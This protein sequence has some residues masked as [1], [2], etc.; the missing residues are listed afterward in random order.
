MN[1]KR[2]LTALTAAAAVL[3][4]CATA[5]PPAPS[6]AP[7]AASPEP[8]LKS[9]LDLAGF[10]RSV[11]PQDDL[12]RFVG[13]SWLANTEIPA[14]RSNYGTFQR[15]EDD[16]QAAVRRLVERAA[17]A[18]DAVPGSELQRIGSFYNS[19][20]DTER[21]AS[22]GV[23]PVQGEFAAIAG[24]RTARDIYRWMGRAQRIGLSHPLEFY[25]GQD[26]RNSSAYIAVV[27]QSGLTMPDRDY[28]LKPDATNAEF[29][30]QY[31][32]YVERLLA[33]AGD[34]DAA[35]SAKRIAALETRL[36]NHHWTKVANRDPLKSHNN[37]TLR[38]A[39]QLA[40]G[41]DWASFLDG[42]GAGEVAAIDIRQ[43]TY[44]R[45][46]ARL[47]RMT[48][49]GDWRAY[50]K[51]RVL[52]AY[53]PYLS[54]DFDE[55]QFAFH[56]G[57][58]GGVQ[59]QRP[60]W[61][62]GVQ[63][64]G[65]LMGEA[66]GRLY[67]EE[68]FSADSKARMQALV[69]NLLRAFD[70]SID[71]L[72][73]L[74]PP[75]K[76]EAKRKLAKFTVKIG[77]PDRW[78]DYSKL[79]I[80]ASDLVGNVRRAYEFEFQRTLAKLGQPLDRTEWLMTPQT[81]N[82][83]YYPPMNEIVFPAAILRPP[84][85]DPTADDA[86][87]YG[88]IGAV[89]GHE[90][91]HGFDDQGRQYDGDGNLRDWWTLDDDTRF[92]ARADR[93]VAQFGG[94]DVIDGKRLNGNLTLGE[95]IGDLSGLT[96]AYKAYLLSLRGP[97]GV[98]RTAPV[99]DG[100]S[101]PQRFFLGWAQIWRRKYRDDEMRKRLVMDPHS[102]SEFR[103]NGVVTNMEEFYEAFA[104]REGDRLYRTAADRVKIW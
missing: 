31:Q 90:I 45:E 37:V 38:Q 24:L 30:A 42:A 93:L 23:M 101:G 33:L 64:L 79:E 83:Y 44:V 3:C 12:Y 19:F 29:R 49:P 76:A 9:G 35:S 99:V 104:V 20:M 46:L 39:A 72:E 14:D 58:L 59:Q 8:P 32:R 27:E 22:L 18:R 96:V 48:P 17:A 13:G 66:L 2:L 78:R 75:S 80:T 98:V 94:Y 71:E 41:F 5:P 25:V 15:L 86:V 91:S 47:V 57:V 56:E 82:A 7:V 34:R 50:F 88:A 4:G 54:G 1:A 73:W 10:D 28:Y 103:V 6:P 62:R 65:G 100:F 68:Q 55:A 21:L 43:P 11:R 70:A 51:F 89:I 95:N 40:P 63:T 102:P 77:Y 36:A 92:H 84:F 97:D 69:A 16:S 52:D 61:K 87:N 60:R 74:S 85:F 67:V 26:S 81:V 53:A